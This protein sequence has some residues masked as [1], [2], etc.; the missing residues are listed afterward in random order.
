MER[1]E[2]SPQL[3]AEAQKTVHSPNL[4]SIDSDTTPNNSAYVPGTPPQAL[5]YHKSDKPKPNSTDVKADQSHHFESD[6]E[7]ISQ[8]L[9]LGAISQPTL[10]ETQTPIFQSSDAVISKTVE[11][12][13][14]LHQLTE[15][16]RL[17]E[18]SQVH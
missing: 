5:D 9:V 12:T 2:K 17:W 13:Q 8:D 18:N 4:S 1:A 7:K 11:P 16:V 10:A 6:P 14:S 15:T 3:S